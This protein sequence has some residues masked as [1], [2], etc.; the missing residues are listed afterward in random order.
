MAKNGALSNSSFYEATPAN[1]AFQPLPPLNWMDFAALNNFQP[2]QWSP[3]ERRPDGGRG[4][5]SVDTSMMD[6]DFSR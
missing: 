2:G 5:P 4:T 6:F 3:A 1:A